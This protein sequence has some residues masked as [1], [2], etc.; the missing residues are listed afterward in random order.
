MKK[1]KEEKK[2]KK[3]KNKSL[4]NKWIDNVRNVFKVDIPKTTP[5]IMRMFFKDYDEKNSIIQLDDT[6]YSICFEYQDISF[7]KANYETQENIFLKWVAYL[8]SFNYND[9]IQVVCAGRPEKTTNYKQRYI[10]DEDSFENNEKKIANEF[11]NLIE[12]SLGNKEEILCE[13]RQVV[14]TTTAE[15]MKDAQDIFMQ[16]QLRTEEKFKEL[17]SKVRR[18]SVQE[19]LATIYNVFHTEL[20]DIK[21]IFEYAK[22]NELSI[23]DVLAPKEDVYLREKN[24]ISI[25]NKKF[26]RVMFVSKFPKSITPRFYNRITTIENCNIITTLN[27]TPKSPAEYIKKTNKAISGMKTERLAKIKRALK[28]NYSYEVVKDEKLEDSLEDALNMR[29]ALQKKKQKVFTNNVLICIQADSLAELNDASKNIK[30]IAS[31]YSLGIQNLDWQQLEGLQNCLPFGWNSLQMQRSL[32]SEATATN[33]PFNTKDLMHPNSI[34]HGINLVSK[35][36]V[37]CDR[38]KLLN[39]NGCVLATSGAGKS[40]SIK[41]IIEQVML[42]YPQDEI[43][44][45]DPQR[46]I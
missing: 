19:R 46:R 38:K 27:I 23:Y 36:P 11:N 37:F 43:I 17:K 20:M 15:S 24:Y 8:H 13:T 42:R 41:V 45:L 5:Q 7:A 4:F 40:F 30:S 14:I 32:T 16:Y 29:E 3:N 12:T 10:Y 2:V 35:N 26:I 33:V 1:K 25:N 31:E 18:V 21:N 28:N 22:E 44:V 34:Y 6:H 39:G 9:H